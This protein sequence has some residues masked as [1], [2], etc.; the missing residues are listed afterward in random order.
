MLGPVDLALVGPGVGHLAVEDGQ[1]AVAD[2]VLL[3]EV[4]VRLLALHDLHVV[5]EPPDRRLVVVDGAGQRHLGLRE[6][7]VLLRERTRE[8]EV[9][10]GLWIGRGGVS[11]KWAECGGEE[12]D[13]LLSC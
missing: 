6:G 8:L 13:F 3:D 2:D 12:V 11:K 10:V 1:L 9:N 4:L 5:L 7:V